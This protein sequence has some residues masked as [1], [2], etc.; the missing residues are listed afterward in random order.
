MGSG[1]NGKE[2][3]RGG[4]GE[5]ERRGSGEEGEE[6][7][8]GGRRGVEVEKERRGSGRVERRGVER[9][10]KWSEEEGEEWRGVERR[11]REKWVE[12]RGV[13]RRRREEGKGEWEEEWRG[14][15]GEKESKRLQLRHMNNRLTLSNCSVESRCHPALSLVKTYSV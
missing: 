3:W 13:E 15:G 10:E 5:V 1:E 14:G 11:S 12:W 7:W 6:E 8:R 9:K 4:V 2:E